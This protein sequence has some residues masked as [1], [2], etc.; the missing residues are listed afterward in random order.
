MVSKQQKLNQIISDI[1]GEGTKELR[2]KFEYKSKEHIE[3]ID[4]SAYNQAQLEELDNQ[5]TLIRNMID[6]AV[7]RLHKLINA[8]GRTGR[9]P[10]SAADRA[11]AI[12][13]QQYFMAS[14]RFCSSLVWLFREKL[15]VTERLTAKDIERAYDDSDV[16]AILIEV[17]RM[18]N[19][20]VR[21]KE[22]EFSID[23]TGMPTSI[24]Q[25]YENDK[26]DQN[27]KAVYDMLIGMIGVN[28]KLFTAFEITGPGSECP[29]LIPLLEETKE[30]YT[31]ID[32]VSADALYLARYN[33]TAIANAGATPYIFPKEGITLK[34][35]GS[36]AWKKML[37][38]LID[39]P[40]KWLREYHKRSLS[41]SV[42][43]VWK[44]KFLR[45]LAREDDDRRKIEAFARVVC[46]NIRRLPYLHY[47]QNIEVPWLG[48]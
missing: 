17:F 30:M 3:S 7:K 11:K 42:N 46:Y 10:K 43:S 33:C 29:C 2:K 26:G 19:E 20:P 12:L 4:W 8:E 13:M 22:T 27:K 34:Q 25:N 14:D 16:V 31:R 36:V 5:I 44:R 38:A 48:N 1:K 41:E 47:L 21:D 23:G 24:K 18:S 6:E 35:K 40:Q 15:G 28:T 32:K 45:P 9:P 37:L 39:D